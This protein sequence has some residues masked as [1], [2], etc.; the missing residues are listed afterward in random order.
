MTARGE[1]NDGFGE[2]NDGFGSRMMGL[3]SRMMGFGEQNYGL[4]GVEALESL[5]N[6]ASVHFPI[7]G[8]QR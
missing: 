7:A 1:Q 5:K 3:E 6:R 8:T 4:L 2:Q